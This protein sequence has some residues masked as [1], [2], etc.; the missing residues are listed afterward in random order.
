MVIVIE[1]GFDDTS[2]NPGQ[3]CFAFHK[4]VAHLGKVG[5]QLFRYGQT[6]GLTGLFDLGMATNLGERKI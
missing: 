1:N 5:F 2:S 6:E 4:S 3:V